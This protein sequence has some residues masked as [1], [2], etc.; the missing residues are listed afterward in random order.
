MFRVQENS[1]DSGRPGASVALFRV[2]HLNSGQNLALESGQ[3]L[4]DEGGRG[5]QDDRG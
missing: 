4:A 1:R 5:G 2:P 3:E